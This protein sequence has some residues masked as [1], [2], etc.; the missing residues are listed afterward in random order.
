M[1]QFAAGPIRLAVITRSI[2]Q[3]PVSR[4]GRAA[5]V[6]LCLLGLAA[7]S[8]LVAACTS[9]SRTQIR[10]VGSSTV[11]PFTTAVAEQF[12]RK[13]PEF[14]APIVESTG[15]GGGIKLMCAG[16]GS[17]FPDA[18]NASRRI[19]KSELEDCAKH[20]VKGLIELQVGIDGLVIAQSRAGSFPGLT[21]RDVYL[22]LAANP[23]GKGPNT[24]RTWRD[25]NPALPDIR[26]EVIG[27]PPTSGTRDSFN[28]LYMLKGCN[29]EPAM[30]ALKKS[31]QAAH[32]QICEKVREDGAFIEGGE[33][34]N[35]IVQK[36]A[37]NP[38][39]LGVFG[40]S[41]VEENSDKVKD[42]PLGGVAA[43]YDN[44]AGGS[45]PASRPLYLYVKA[46]HVPAV[47]GMREFLAEYAREST[48]GRG[49]YLAR[50]GLVAAPEAVRRA[51]ERVARDLT[52]MD[53]SSVK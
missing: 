49:G 17:Q 5:R 11:Y 23:F 13:W 8:L 32:K 24:A 28:E 48:W 7:T 25:V 26:I 50:K 18:A 20:G 51:G 21:E 31:D 2:L 6:R 30:K 38:Q 41:F 39:A 1:G 45:F 35:L 4:V 52:L 22:A 53:E 34:D 14:P 3:Q 42:V 37:A 44:I 27:P 9:G 40:Y 10:I 15:T 12:K 29:S 36:I 47:R 16:L 46:Q 43:T 19:K 33:N